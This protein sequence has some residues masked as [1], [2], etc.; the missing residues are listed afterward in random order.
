MEKEIRIVLRVN[1]RIQRTAVDSVH[2]IDQGAPGRRSLES[3]LG[4]KP[5]NFAAVG[6]VVD[7][8]PDLPLVVRAM[9][10][11]VGMKDVVVG[12]WRVWTVRTIGGGSDRLRTTLS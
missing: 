4:A 2:P 7:A 6:V 10:R 5:R 3:E 12:A 11:I 9:V 8:V 1:R